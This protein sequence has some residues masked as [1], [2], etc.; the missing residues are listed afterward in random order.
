MLREV[1]GC[2]GIVKEHL[3]TMYLSMIADS[4]RTACLIG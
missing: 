4:N 2:F 1:R 3:L